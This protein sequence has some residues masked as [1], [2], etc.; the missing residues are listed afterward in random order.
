MVHFFPVHC[1]QTGWILNVD[2]VCAD[3]TESLFLDKGI[4]N[5]QIYMGLLQEHKWLTAGLE[6]IS[7]VCKPLKVQQELDCDYY[8]FYPRD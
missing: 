2:L 8:F 7:W 3:F 5:L 6:P 4:W 1:F